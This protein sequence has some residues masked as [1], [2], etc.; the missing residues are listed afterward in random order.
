[1]PGARRAVP[2]REKPPKAGAFPGAVSVNGRPDYRTLR[3][4]GWVLAVLPPGN[5]TLQCGETAINVD[6]VAADFGD[7]AVKAGDLAPQE[8]ADREDGADRKVFAHRGR[9]LITDSGPPYRTPDPAAAGGYAS[10]RHGTRTT[11]DSRRKRRDRLL[12][13]RHSRRHPARHRPGVR[14]HLRGRP[15]AREPHHTRPPIAPRGGDCDNGRWNA[16]A[17]HL[18]APPSGRP[19][20]TPKALTGLQESQGSNPL[21][22]RHTRL[23]TRTAVLGSNQIGAIRPILPRDCHTPA[24]AIGRA[25]PGPT[26]PVPAFVQW[27]PV[28]AR[29]SGLPAPLRAAGWTPRAAVRF[30]AALGAP[31]G[32]AAFGPP[33]G[34]GCSGLRGLQR[35]AERAELADR[36]RRELAAPRADARRD[37]P[38]P[39]NPHAGA[40]PLGDVF[41]ARR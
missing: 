36:Q 2:V 27:R 41:V 17:R 32:C 20:E 33:G 19:R 29:A 15:P 28:S 34:S 21:W 38:L 30:A 18:F 12:V 26:P 25:G 23:L 13:G 4:G 1:M 16:P 37:P 22:R 31:A 9:Q 10:A 6:H 35:P 7:A 24:T 5:P 40:P 8:P 39:V 14:T 3:P 11:L